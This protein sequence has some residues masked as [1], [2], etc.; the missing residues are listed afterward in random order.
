[1]CGLVGIVNRELVKGPSD[2]LIKAFSQ[3]LYCDALRGKHGTGILGVDVD[4]D[5]F[6]Y[7]KALSSA[8]FLEL[9]ITDKIISDDSNV[10]LLGHNRWATQGAHTATNAHPFNHGHIHLFHN[11][12]L[13][14][15]RGLNPGKAFTV[16]SDAL[17]CYISNQ[18]DTL[19]ALE[20]IDGAF[21]LVWYDSLKETL[22]FAR[23]KDRPMFFGSI[24]DSDSFLYASEAGML[25]WIAGRNNITLEKIITLEV[26]NWLSVPL[27]LNETSKPVIKEFK[28][29][30][31][32]YKWE[33]YYQSGRYNPPTAKTGL[34]VVKK[35]LKYSFLESKKKVDVLVEKWVPY[36]N[37]DANNAHAFGYL[38]TSLDHLEIRV[39]SVKNFE[40]N[41]LIGE[42]IPIKVTNV[43]T[44][45]LAYARRLTDAEVAD[46]DDKKK[47]Q[48][49][50]K[51]NYVGQSGA[52]FN[53]LAKDG[54]F[55]CSCTIPYDKDIFVKSMTD[56]SQILC[57]DCANEYEGFN[58]AI[59]NYEDD[60]DGY[61][62]YY[63][64]SN[65][66]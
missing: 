34:T 59:F 3:M 9:D 17:A 18:E 53:K 33:N 12:T 40:A 57:E 4:G 35:H 36:N 52:A 32:D 51:L 66:I 10:F 54:C 24:K 21:S 31:D 27:T 46:I 45:E 30:E 64:Q 20:T 1:M 60:E 29:R 48:E 16:D 61:I 19:K 49:R 6:E 13:N 63:N 23:N 42:I 11:G 62:K 65:A 25:S 39:S 55:N 50:S 38:L 2:N 58:T 56:T 14:S 8:D 26:G 22:N 15:F 43:A 44:D 28:P 37:A 5:I 47:E 41:K 7:K